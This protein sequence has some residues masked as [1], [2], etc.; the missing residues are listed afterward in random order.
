M[1]KF[2]RRESQQLMMKEIYTAL[3]DSR[4]S[5][6]EAGT[7]TGKTLAYL[8]PSLYFAKRKEE[9]V[10]ISTQ[11]VQ[12]QQQI[13]EKRNSVITKKIMPFSFEVALLKGRKHY[14]CLHKF[15]YA[16]QEEEKKL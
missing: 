9:P 8:L 7:G 11:T 14:L 16:L 6:I 15:E 13:L 12:L 1:P 10:I 5:L 4:F 3:R 2:E